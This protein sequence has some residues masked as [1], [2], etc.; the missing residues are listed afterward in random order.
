M[1]KTQ[2]VEI[3]PPQSKAEV[4]ASE[5]ARETVHWIPKI[6]ISLGIFLGFWI[7]AALV[8]KTIHRVTQHA[9][10]SKQVVFRLLTQMVKYA[11]LCLGL[12]TALGTLGINVSALVA[13]LGLTGFALGFALKDILSNV[14]SG[15]LILLFQPF[16]IQDQIKVSG[17]EGTVINIDLRYT[18]LTSSDSKYILI[19]NSTIFINPVVI[20]PAQIPEVAI[21]T[22][23]TK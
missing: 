17:F 20:T 9:K 16:Q 11:L 18:V 19:P 15:T 23:F 3:Q 2:T 13:G 10:P 4:A 7:G 6:G 12:A 21:P 8:V 1:A 14:V 5:A 22:S